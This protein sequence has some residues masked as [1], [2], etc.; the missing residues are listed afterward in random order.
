MKNSSGLPGGE[1]TLGT[2][3]STATYKTKQPWNNIFKVYEII[4]QGF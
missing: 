1:K 2:N 4:S 3:F